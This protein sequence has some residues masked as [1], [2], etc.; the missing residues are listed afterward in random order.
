MAEKNMDKNRK[1]TLLELMTSNDDIRMY[2]K[3]MS[4]GMNRSC[5]FVRTLKFNNVNSDM[6]NKYP[7]IILTDADFEK[8]YRL[9][10]VKVTEYPAYKDRIYIAKGRL[11]ENTIVKAD[12]NESLETELE[13][14][15]ERN[16]N[17]MSLI[18]GLMRRPH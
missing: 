11:L 12:S 2:R 8:N 13:G 17:R 14:I 18:P 6:L 1:E 7:E 3:F 10:D 15:V 9:Y 5:I 16:R 4:R